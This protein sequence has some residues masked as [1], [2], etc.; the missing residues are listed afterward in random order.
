MKTK[1][2]IDGYNLYYGRLKNTPYK[3]L[4]IAK[5]FTHIVRVQSP[6]SELLAIDY[7]TAPCLGRF[8]RHPKAVQIQQSYLRA[9]AQDPILNIVNGFH[10]AER[11]HLPAYD[12]LT[13]KLDLDCKQWVWR[14]EEKQTD[15]NIVLGLV[16]DAVDQTYEQLVVVSNDSDL[17]P[18]LKAIRDRGLS[19]TIGAVVPAQPGKKRP[20]SAG[21]MRYADWTRHHILDAE[22]AEA[23]LP[24]KI[25]TR[26][27][28]IIK[29]NHW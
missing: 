27:K 15:V 9:L 17:E 28:P 18:A 21:L 16:L 14:V 8:S 23:Q 1:V 2:Y 11:A 12:L 4:D 26:K 29:P 22:L 19:L 6:E 20:P 25:P 7:F 3:W 10:T 24:D 5:L 13:K